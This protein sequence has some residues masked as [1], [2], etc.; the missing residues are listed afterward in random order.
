MKAKTIECKVC[1][2]QPVCNGLL[3]TQVKLGLTT[4]RQGMKISVPKKK[5]V[6]APVKKQRK[7]RTTSTT[8]VSDYG[9]TTPTKKVNDAPTR[10]DNP[11][12]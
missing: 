2:Y 12:A 8:T 7:P 3:Y 1:K 6:V 5:A 9:Q 4:C 10:S 11:L